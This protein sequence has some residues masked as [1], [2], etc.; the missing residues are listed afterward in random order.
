MGALCSVETWRIRQ[1]SSFCLISP[2]LPPISLP[3]RPPLLFR[4]DRQACY[5]AT[6]LAWGRTR[7]PSPENANETAIMTPLAHCYTLTCVEEWHVFMFTSV[8]TQVKSLRTAQCWYGNSSVYSSSSITLI[9]PPIVTLLLARF[10][11]PFLRKDSLPAECS[12]MLLTLSFIWGVI[13][14]AY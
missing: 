11:S 13:L 10:W 4:G 14:W 7:C 12:T 6:V 5:H 2:P 8:P 3:L 9:T 1:G